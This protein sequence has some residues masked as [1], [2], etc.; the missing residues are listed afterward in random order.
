MKLSLLV[1]A[2]VFLVTA[3]TTIAYVHPV[4]TRSTGTLTVLNAKPNSPAQESSKKGHP[5]FVKKTEAVDRRATG[6]KKW[7]VDKNEDDEYWFNPKIHTLG[8]RGFFG[9]LHAAIAPLS[10]KMIDILAYEGV[11]V[12]EKVAQELAATLRVNKAHIVDLCCGVGISTRA[13]RKAFPDAEEVIGMDTSPEMVEMARA[14]N[15]HDS[16]LQPV[17][18]SIKASFVGMGQSLQRQSVALRN[19]YDQAQAACGC[20]ATFALGNAEHTDLPAKSF[21]LVTI[22]YAFHEAPKKGRDRILREARRLL[23]KGGLLALIDISPDYQASKS[24]LAG[25]PYVLEYQSNIDREMRRFPGFAQGKSKTLV[26]GHV[27]MWLLERV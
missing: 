3:K 23:N 12:R 25:E 4:G 5:A 1:T 15:I 8:T 9:G 6:R 19:A 18:D 10:T 16:F 14:I 27:K 20:P 2:G 24:M 21:D 7:G 13:L 26:P 11:D 22:M 17:F